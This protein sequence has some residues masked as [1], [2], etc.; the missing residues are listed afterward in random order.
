MVVASDSAHEHCVC[1]E[2]FCNMGGS[3]GDSFCSVSLMTILMLLLTG[4]LKCM[5]AS[6]F[7]KRIGTVNLPLFLRDIHVV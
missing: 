3:I 2:M 7:L 4:N 5:V 1:F 6:M